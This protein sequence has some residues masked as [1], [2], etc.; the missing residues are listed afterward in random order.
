MEA[1]HPPMTFIQGFAKEMKIWKF[2]GQHLGTWQSE[3]CMTKRPPRNPCETFHFRHREAVKH[4]CSCGGSFRASR[5]GDSPWTP[6]AWLHRGRAGRSDFTLPPR[7]FPKHAGGKLTPVPSGLRVERAMHGPGVE[8]QAQP[9]E[10]SS[11]VQKVRDWTGS[12]SRLCQQV[13]GREKWKKTRT[14]DC[15]CFKDKWD[16]QPLNTMRPALM[17]TSKL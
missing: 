11:Q 8:G 3:L 17:W 4:R 16:V 2:P 15:I 7:P 14:E 6:L 1:G 13:D 9:Q 5:S 12:F 10:P